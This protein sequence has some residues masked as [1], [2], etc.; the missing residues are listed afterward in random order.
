[1]TPA[2]WQEAMRVATVLH[3]A[4]CREVARL[5]QSLAF[6]RRTSTRVF[7]CPSSFPLYH[8]EAKQGESYSELERVKALR[9]PYAPDWVD[10]MGRVPELM[11]PEI[12]EADEAEGVQP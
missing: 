5:T 6:E 8:A 12:D 1:M 7:D 9:P 4:R 11:M 10:G 2:E 3:S